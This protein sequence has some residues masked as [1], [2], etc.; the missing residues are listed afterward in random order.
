MI[1]K[2]F[3]WIASKFIVYQPIKIVKDAS[4][5]YLKNS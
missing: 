5:L 4:F 2:K 1:L 3:D